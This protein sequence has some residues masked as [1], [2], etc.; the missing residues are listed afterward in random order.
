MDTGGS[1]IGGISDRRLRGC[2]KAKVLVASNQHKDETQRST[3]PSNIQVTT[4]LAPPNSAE[5]GSITP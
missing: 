3:K 2:N 1:G 4:V 5:V